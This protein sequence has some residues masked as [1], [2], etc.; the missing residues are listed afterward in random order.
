[1]VRTLR[2]ENHAGDFKVT[3]IALK[4]Q[5]VTGSHRWGERYRE[6]RM[7]QPVGAATGGIAVRVIP[8]GEA[9]RPGKL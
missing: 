7:R 2:K 8:D 3:N 4:S 1:M 9:R 5:K 6:P